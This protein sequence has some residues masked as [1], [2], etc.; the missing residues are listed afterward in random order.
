MPWWYHHSRPENRHLRRASSGD[1]HQGQCH[2]RRGR[3]GLLQGVQP[4][5][6]SGECGKCL[7]IH[8][9]SGIYNSSKYSWNQKLACRQLKICLNQNLTKKIFRTFCLIERKLQDQCCLILTQPLTHG[10]LGDENFT[11]IKTRA[12]F[13]V[14]NARWCNCTYGSIVWYKCKQA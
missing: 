8:P 4:N 6:L 13:V 12:M 10:E 7:S 14:W 9:A 11:W 2:S 5:V 3:G 1:P